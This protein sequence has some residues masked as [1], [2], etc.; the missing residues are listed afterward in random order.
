MRTRRRPEAFKR[1]S[2]Q[3][4]EELA[5]SDVNVD[6]GDGSV[7]TDPS[8]SETEGGI[9]VNQTVNQA[10]AQSNAQQQQQQQGVVP[11]VVTSTGQTQVMGTPSVL[12]PL[13]THSQAQAL[14][15]QFQALLG[16]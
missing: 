5:M 6:P 7:T 16:L 14:L 4:Q 3:S 8:S 2:I 12:I 11:V 13:S 15:A 10:Q 1:Q 9:T